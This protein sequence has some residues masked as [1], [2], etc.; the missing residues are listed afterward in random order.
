MEALRAYLTP[1]ARKK[2]RLDDIDADSALSEGDSDAEI[3][4]APDD[5]E[6]PPWWAAQQLKLMKEMKDTMS[7]FHKLQTDVSDIKNELSHVKLQTGLA[8]SAAEEALEVVTNVEDRVKSLEQ[9]CLSHDAIQKMIDDAISEMKKTMAASTERLQ[10]IAPPTAGNSNQGDEKFCR[11]L[12]VGS[13]DQDTAKDD[14][15]KYLSDS[16]FKDVPG[17]EETYAYTHGSV[18]FVRF[19]T[20]DAMYDFLK[21]FSRK[22]KPQINGKT[23]FLLC[24]VRICL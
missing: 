16:I 15:V 21:A 18:G 13:F 2:Q 1:N 20:K 5:N 22:A 6:Q 19:V 14:V 11:T 10:R 3:V 12:V 7:S 8:Q 9:E 4:E 23:V 17:I 24:F